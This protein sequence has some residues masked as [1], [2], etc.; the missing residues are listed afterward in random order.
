MRVVRQFEIGLRGV[1]GSWYPSALGKD[2]AMAIVRWLTSYTVWLC[3]WF[4]VSPDYIN[5][6]KRGNLPPPSGG[7]GA[8]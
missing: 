8:Y 7:I 3:K 6:N 4:D 1:N 5:R 2:P